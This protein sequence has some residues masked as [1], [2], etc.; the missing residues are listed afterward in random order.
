[1]SEE[2]ALPLWYA[3]N[4]P[5]F[6]PKE[7]VDRGVAGSV[8]AAYERERV[9]RLSGCGAFRRWCPGPA[10]GRLK[11]TIGAEEALGRRLE[12]LRGYGW[13]VLADRLVPGTEARIP[14]ILV[15]P[16]GVVVVN[17]APASGPWAL[18]DGFVF[19]RGRRLGGWMSTRLWE[20]RMVQNA[21]AAVAVDLDWD[22]PT[23]MVVAV[24]PAT[25][26]FRRTVP[27]DSVP[28]HPYAVDGIPFVSYHHVLDHVLDYPAPLPR[29]V[30]AH[31]A[32]MLEEVCPPAGVRDAR[33]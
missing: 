7:R 25:G 30:A 31:L 24:P 8:R 23:R 32:Y 1:M 20:A 16:A 4:V 22:G 17:P 11:V 21:L 2:K 28:K 27:T 13:T 29:E 26:T 33:G 12:P 19:L 6:V 9:V 14:F 5:A 10:E 15:G 3:P 18:V